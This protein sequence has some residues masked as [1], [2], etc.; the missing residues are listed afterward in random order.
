VT[1]KKNKPVGD[2]SV[3]VIEPNWFRTIGNELQLVGTYCSQCR[4]TFFPLKPGTLERF[5]H[6][7]KFIEKT[8][9]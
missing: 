8:Y 7:T 6:K 2:F 1:A 9:E 4:K 5:T 3:V